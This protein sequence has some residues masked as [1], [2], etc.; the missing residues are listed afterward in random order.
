M[1]FYNAD[2]DDEGFAGQG[3]GIDPPALGVVSLK[4]EISSCVP[5]TG[6]GS[7]DLLSQSW[8]NMNGLWGGNPWI[9]PLGNETEW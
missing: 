9:D 7:G 1:F 4:E 2:N 6:V 3:Y 5:F 8:N